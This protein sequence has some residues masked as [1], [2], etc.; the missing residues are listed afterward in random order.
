MLRR[1]DLHDLPGRV[2][3]KLLFSPDT[4]ESAVMSRRT[5]VV[6]QGG[7]RQWAPVMNAFLQQPLLPI[8]PILPPDVRTTRGGI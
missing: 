1:A 3:S 4:A 5:S 7:H 8:G 6:R 2:K